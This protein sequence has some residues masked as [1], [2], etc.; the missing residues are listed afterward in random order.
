M[1]HLASAA[2]MNDFFND[3]DSVEVDY[4]KTNK[5][6]RSSVQDPIKK[7]ND[8]NYIQLIITEDIADSVL[9]EL[10]VSE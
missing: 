8:G 7:C 5:N 3:Q 6:E 2:E 10:Q 1:L 9:L 4:S